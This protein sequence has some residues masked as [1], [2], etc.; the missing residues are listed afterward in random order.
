V[1][2]EV[3]MRELVGKHLAPLSVVRMPVRLTPQ[4]RADYERLGA[5][6]LA[7]SREFFRRSR[8]SDYAALLRF[9]AASPEGRMA[10][11]ER[12]RAEDIAHFPSAKRTLVSAL[13][14]RHAADRTILFT[15]RAE[16]AYRIAENE[17]V[18][19]ITGEVRTRERERIL[20]D[21]QDGRIRAIVSARVLNEGIDVPDAR[22]AIVVG[23]TLGAREHVQR[24]GRV[25]RPAPDKEA[26]AYEI[27][28]VGT[29]DE[30]RAFSRGRNAPLGI[31]AQFPH[32]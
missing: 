10:L 9:L 6:F 12:A 32:S 11:R 24:I 28:T 15:A 29:V 8:D 14:A 19:A 4:E 13:L 17:L 23:G 7:L 21:F 18:P 16:D 22:V 31:S 20:R 30:R 1:V 2:L 5:R 26:V 25:L 3:A 27:F